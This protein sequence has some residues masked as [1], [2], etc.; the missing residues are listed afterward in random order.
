MSLK[1][2]IE[3]AVEKIASR[4]TPRTTCSAIVA[5]LSLVKSNFIA[6]Q[7]R[8]CCMAALGQPRTQERDEIKRLICDYGFKV[9]WDRSDWG[10]VKA[11]DR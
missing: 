10:H 3:V 11:H 5:L 6:N 8:F 4:M 1:R 2:E 7:C 9:T